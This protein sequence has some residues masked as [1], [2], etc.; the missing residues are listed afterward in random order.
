MLLVHTPIIELIG[1]YETLSMIQWGI[2]ALVSQ[3]VAQFSSGEHAAITR[4]VSEHRIQL[5]PP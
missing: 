5:G 4:I 2:L 3:E 1:E